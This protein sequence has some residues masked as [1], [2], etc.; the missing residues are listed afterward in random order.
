MLW[1]ARILNPE[2]NPVVMVVADAEP[3]AADFEDSLPKGVERKP[4]KLLFR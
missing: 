2:Q 1:M 3:L 4:I